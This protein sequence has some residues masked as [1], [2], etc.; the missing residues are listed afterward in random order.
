V[1]D[2]LEAPE[3]VSPAWWKLIMKHWARALIGRM[4]M[5]YR[6]WEHV[7]TTKR[8]DVRRASYVD[9]DTGETGEVIQ[10]GREI[11]LATRTVEWSESIPA[12]TGYLQSACRAALADLLIEAGERRVLYADTDSL[13]ATGDHFDYMSGL[14][15]RHP[16]LGL[17]L[18][19]SWRGVEIRGPRQL[20]TG[21]RVRV[22]GIPSKAERRAD[23]SL[24]GEVWESLPAA[25]SARRPGSIR[26][27]PRVWHLRAVDARRVAGPDG[28]TEPIRTGAHVDSVGRAR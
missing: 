8:I 12:V 10:V 15:G 3:E 5:T 19:R 23:G 25:I 18:K 16:E 22:S 7:T 6:E 13:L 1:I 26:I 28:W 2:Q 27:T 21:Q 11:F 20:V 9:I 17:R 4:A 24:A 14:A